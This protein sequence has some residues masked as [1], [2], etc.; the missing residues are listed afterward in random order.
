MNDIKTYFI[1]IGVICAAIIIGVPTLSIK[2]GPSDEAAKQE[3]VF[4]TW[5]EYVD[6]DLIKAFEEKFSAKVKYIYF[7]TE[8]ERE[9]LLSLT[10]G[11]GYDVVLASGVNTLSYIRRNWLVPLNSDRIPNLKH[12]D[13]KWFSANPKITAYAV[14]YLWGTLGIA[15][16]KDLIKEEVTSWKQLYEPDEKL[17]GKILMINDSRHAISTQ[18]QI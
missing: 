2:A 13:Q 3:L 10:S 6:P 14:L 17:H 18:L 7:E 16:R 15:C 12:I 1:W 5:S 11:K 9:Q 4:L 8:D